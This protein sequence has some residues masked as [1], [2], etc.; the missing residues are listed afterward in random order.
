MDVE[1]KKKLDLKIAKDIFWY[2]NTLPYKNRAL[3]VVISNHA[4]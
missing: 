3:C 1:K 4:I 2:Q